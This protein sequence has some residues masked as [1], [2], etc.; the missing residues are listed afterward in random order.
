M[1]KSVTIL[2]L[3]FDQTN[4]SILVQTIPKEAELPHLGSYGF[5]K[6]W[7]FVNVLGEN[8]EW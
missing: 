1:D 3:S 7:D 5:K 6:V 8:W 2:K 4:L